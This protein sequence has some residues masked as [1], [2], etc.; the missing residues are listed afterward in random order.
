MVTEYPLV[1]YQCLDKTR[2]LKML[3]WTG[4]ITKEL[5]KFILKIFLGSNDE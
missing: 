2:L 1:L 5:F 4:P 3:P